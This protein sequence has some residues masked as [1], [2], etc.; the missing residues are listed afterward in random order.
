[1]SNVAAAGPGPELSVIVPTFNERDNVHELKAAWMFQRGQIPPNR[2]MR[3]PEALYRLETL[4]AMSMRRKWKGTPSA[5]G[6]CS[7]VRR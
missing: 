3:K 1:M 7:V 5:P 4:P 6:R 2:G